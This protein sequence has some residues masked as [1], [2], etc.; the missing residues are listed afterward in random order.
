[1]ITKAEIK[2]IRSLSDKKYREVYGLFTV[3]GE[4]LV[5]EAVDSG[6]E[7]EKIYYAEDIGE[8]TMSKISLLASPSPALALV[9]IP[10]RDAPE[11]IGK[12][13]YIALDAIRDPGNMG[14]II[15][16]AEWF[17]IES[18]F[19]SQDCVDI[20]NPKVVQS[21]MGSIF[22]IPIVC[23]DLSLLLK[24]ATGKTHIF[25]TYLKG[26]SIYQERLPSDAIIVMGNESNGISPKLDKHIH[27]RINI[28]SFAATGAGSES[29][30]VAVAAAIVCSEFRRSAV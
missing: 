24:S 18:I 14:T 17:G 30:N 9:R 19:A 27:F 4:K 23:T 12:G 10:R 28:P 21:T 8:D 3:E 25:G 22:R 29:L 1:M 26:R 2:R 13:L 20:Y 11:V 16:L 7:I 5:Q 6:A 15:R